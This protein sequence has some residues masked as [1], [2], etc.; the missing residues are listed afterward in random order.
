[1]SGRFLRLNYD[2]T[3]ENGRLYYNQSWRPREKLKLRWA[4]WKK[5]C[6]MSRTKKERG[7]K[8]GRKEEGRREAGHGWMDGWREGRTK[9]GGRVLILS[10]RFRS[11]AGGRA[12]WKGGW[13]VRAVS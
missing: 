3:V 6:G 11:A 10:S 13:K 4:A 1:M 7:R 9:E 2:C 12:G 5:Y 8:E